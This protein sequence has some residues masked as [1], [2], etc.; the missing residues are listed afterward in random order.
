MS[1][2]SLCAAALLALVATMLAACGGTTSPMPSAP[3]AVPRV[4]SQP[5]AVPP[6]TSLPTATSP[7]PSSG[8]MAVSTTTPQPADVV[9]ELAWEGGFTRPELAFAFGRVPQFSLLP[10]GRAFY[11]DP[12]EWDRAQV[13]VA[14]LAPAEVEAL[15]Q[16][17]QGLGFEGLES[18]AEQCQPQPGGT[19][20]CVMDAGQ[21]I[22]RVRLPSGQVR[23][24]RN[25][26]DFANDPE[27]LSAIRTLL[28]DYRHPAAEAYTPDRAALFVRVVSPPGDDPILDWPL[29]P[30]W[31]TGST[32]DPSCAR[33]VSGSDLQALLAATGRNLG[34]FYFRA[35]DTG[36]VYDVYLVP[37]LPGVDYAELI[38]SSGQACPPAA[39]PASTAAVVS[40]AL[41]QD[42]EI[43]AQQLDIPVE[44]AMRQLSLQDL[45]GDLNAELEQR[46]ADTFAG[47]WIQHEPEYGIV[48]AF[49]RD[50]E[51]TLQRYVAGTPLDGLVQVRKARFTYAELVAAGQEVGRLVQEL[52][53][54]FSWGSDVEGNRIELWVTDRAQFEAALEQAR[55]SLP[56][57]VQIVV[58]YEPLVDVPDGLTPVPDVDF[59]QVRA[60]TTVDLL[61]DLPGLLTMEDGCLRIVP[62]GEEVGYLIIWQPDYFLNDN[63]GVLEVWDREGQVVA[64]VGQAITLGLGGLPGDGQ[65]ETFL[66][67]PLPAQCP[68][69]YWLMSSFK[70]SPGPAELPPPTVEPVLQPTST[71][72]PAEPLAVLTVRAYIDGRSQLIL[73]GETASWHH[74][75]WA[76]PGRLLGENEP[77]YL[78]GVAWYPSWPDN[79]DAENRD[80]GCD[81]STYVGVAPL[82]PQ[83]QVASL[84]TVQARERV[85]IVQQ[86][87]EDNGYTLIVEFDDGVS[88]GAD[89]YEVDISYLTGS[90]A[91]APCTFGGPYEPDEHT[92]LLLHLDG[93]LAGAQGEAATASEIAFAAGR[94]GQGVMLDETDTLTYPAAGNLADSRGSI[95]FWLRPNWDGDDGGHHTLLWWGEGS[96]FFHLRKDDISNLVF[97]YFYSGGSCGAPAHV[98]AWRAGE[99]HHIGFTWEG[100]EISL[101][102]DG[103]QVGRTICGGTAHPASSA[104][105]IGSGPEGADS[106][107]AIVD[108]F[109]I[110]DIPRIGD[111]DTCSGAPVAPD[112]SLSQAAGQAWNVSYAGQFGG[113]S[114]ATA[115]RGN[116]VY[117]GVGPRLLVLDASHPDQP[118]VVGQSAP[119][120][121]VVRGLALGMGR[122]YVAAGSAGL[123]VL[124]VADPAHPFPIGRLDTPGQAMGVVVGQGRAYVA[125]GEAGLRV[126]NILRPARPVELGFYDTPGYA[127]GLAVAGR[128]AYVADGT[129]GLRVVDVRD[130]GHPVE[131]GFLDTPGDTWGVAVAGHHAF[132][133]DRDGGLRIV[134]VSDP[135]H[136][137]QVGW[138]QTPDMG[139]HV[140]VARGYAYVANGAPEAGLL[141]VDVSDPAHPVPVG[142]TAEPSSAVVVAGRY[143]YVADLESGLRIVDVLRP[144]QPRQVG[145]YHTSGAAVGVAVDGSYAYLS[146]WGGGLHVANIS[147]PERVVAAGFLEGQGWYKR[148]AVS[149]GYGYGA[150]GWGGLRVVDLSDPAYLA[151]EGVYITPG[152]AEDVALWT[153]DDP[154]RR[155]AAVANTLEGLR[156]VD[157]SDPGHPVEVGACDTPGQA[158]GVAV[159]DGYAYVADDEAGLRVLYVGDPK[160]PV[161]RGSYDTPMNAFDVAV[162]GYYAYVAD[163]GSGLRVIDASNP[164]YP[165][166]VG[167]CQTPGPASSVVVKD[168]YAYVAAGDGGLRVIDI[169]DP[170]SPREVGYY[171]TPG[172]AQEVALG[173]PPSPGSGGVDVYLA[174]ADG[175]LLIL[176]FGEGSSK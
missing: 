6:P 78:N 128:Y 61:M 9:L 158:F 69:P 48:A 115:V 140:A 164:A 100:P 145:F 144:G 46:E 54:P 70:Q 169:S 103:Q 142:S 152:H 105:W 51:E 21:S 106:I 148:L 34:D 71:P 72:G 146:A 40:D 37:W 88:A 102:V 18:Y 16:R 108:E 67:E 64:R 150:C 114:Y 44:E 86:P 19:C 124:D 131:V 26:Y 172:W 173:A 53:L 47:L 162:A 65:V 81:S 8:T 98:A 104:F 55:R 134:D 23:E 85:A 32:G 28:Q 96:N 41:R 33:M 5:T 107:D 141:V 170:A 109:R 92:S 127:W 143:A 58:S 99:W 52:G 151:E 10:D 95:E 25:Y 138:Y 163:G 83:E 137:R 60:R 156:L 111:S 74:L 129:A 157:V 97:D 66:R 14:R 27:A 113:R 35:G 153:T 75:D 63:Q 29:P 118:A 89:W 82:A 160:H 112:A 139:T 15:V 20:L 38:A 161:E 68:G 79:P 91:P 1:R 13:M 176:R 90:P 49:T 77:T 110:S 154:P 76:A 117:L 12:P 130:P 149:G 174:D 125:D 120:P 132:L 135:A 123:S 167:F 93:S 62:P 31:L 84:E 116:R 73:R 39:A 43:M 11:L 87:T 122:V 7:C 147:D 22:L 30:A 175:G 119:L 166:E 4:T 101:F 80:C 136:P 126:A 133:A 56:E 3:S 59:P 171:D 121:G 36:R 155:Y 45:A 2:S 165:T 57:P 50:G 159:A 42:A 94:Y 17:V 168:R 24:V